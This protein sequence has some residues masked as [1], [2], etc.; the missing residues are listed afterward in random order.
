M[1]VSG[2][3]YFQIAKTLGVGI[4]TA[5]KDCQIA[6]EQFGEMALQ[7]EVVREGLM[8]LHG[9]LNGA[10]LQSLLQQMNE[11]Q[12][13]SELDKNGDV[14]KATRKNWPNPQIAAELG[15]NL[16]RMA[17]LAGLDTAPVDGGSQSHTTIV[18]SQPND[19]VSFEDRW[20]NAAVNAE[21]CDVSAASAEDAANDSPA[22]SGESIASGVS[23]SPITT[24]PPKSAAAPA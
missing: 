16:Q 9:K 7:P 2:C 23:V 3:S 12:V 13:V 10:L 14:V 17:G 8:A 22:F 21:A 5:H 19:G 1:R 20:K 15:R 6:Q 24:A 4:A 18:L 11:G